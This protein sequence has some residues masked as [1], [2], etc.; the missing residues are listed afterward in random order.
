MSSEQAIAYHSVTF[1]DKNTWDDWKCIP[2]SRP[3]VAPPEVIQNEESTVLAD[4]D[5]DSS[6]SLAGQVLYGTSKGKFE[7]YMTDQERTN[8][9]DFHWLE[10]RSSI[11]E[12]LHNRRRVM[13]LDDSPGYSYEG[14][15]QVSFAPGASYSTMTISYELDVFRRVL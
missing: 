6:A 15:F 8:V 12:Y 3:T 2:V 10:Q 11:L 7:F 9:D 1:G 14:R 4:G 13:I 5:L